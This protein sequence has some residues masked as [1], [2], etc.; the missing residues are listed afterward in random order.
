MNRFAYGNKIGKILKILLFKLKLWEF[1]YFIATKGKGYRVSEGN[2]IYYLI[3]VFDEY[4]HIAEW[5]DNILLLS[6][7]PSNNISWIHP[8]LT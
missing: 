1:V 7:M 8:L 4:S 2:M 3:S 5:A 6:T